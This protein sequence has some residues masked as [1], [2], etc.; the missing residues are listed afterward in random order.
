MQN[1]AR[2][3]STS[4]FLVVS[5]PGGRS[6]KLLL[7][8]CVASRP[9]LG[10]LLR[11]ISG[12]CRNASVDKRVKQSAFTRKKAFPLLRK[13]KDHL[14]ELGADATLPIG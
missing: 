12:D 9:C 6:R 3:S 11:E 1:L 4:R 10:I 8:N 14:A 7:V 2:L 5:C 13:G